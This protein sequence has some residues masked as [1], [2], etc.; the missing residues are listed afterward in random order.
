MNRSKAHSRSNV[1]NQALI[2]GLPSKLAWGVLTHLLL[3]PKTAQIVCFVHPDDHAA[4]LELLTQVAPHKRRRIE[5]II[6]DI[7]ALDFGLVGAVYQRLLSEVTLVHHCEAEVDPSAPLQAAERTNVQGAREVAEF[8]RSAGPQFSRL[9]FWSTAL[10]YG[11][12]PGLV[13][14]DDPPTTKSFAHP[15]LETRYRADRI[16]TRGPRNFQT[17]TLRP[18][19][20]I[21]DDTTL[22]HALGPSRIIDE[23][24]KEPPARWAFWRFLQNKV[25]IVP[26]PHVIALGLKLAAHP[27]TAGH[28]FHI[29]DP[30]APTVQNWVNDIVAKFSQRTIQHTVHDRGRG[31]K[32]LLS[33]PFIGGRLQQALAEVAPAATF[34]ITNLRSLLGAEVEG[35]PSAHKYVDALLGS[36]TNSNADNNVTD[37]AAHDLEL[38]EEEV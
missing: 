12:H 30:N 38:Q 10:A 34:D 7:G 26:L 15:V 14:E 31:T 33:S 5:L 4:T 2:T 6:A 8:V 37:E 13:L 9:V 22:S 36:I 24:S 3:A 21:G 11:G 20:V 25:Q 1:K 23:L 16:I 27:D 32:A 29:V 28:A 35:C 18:T 17:V 19:Y